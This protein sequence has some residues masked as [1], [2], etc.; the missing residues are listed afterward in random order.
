M[1][2]NSPL[3][4]GSQGAIV[5]PPLPAAW[6]QLLYEDF[7]EEKDGKLTQGSSAYLS[8]LGIAHS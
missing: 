4:P 6:A 3:T 5:G 8:A 1:T 7:H 2:S